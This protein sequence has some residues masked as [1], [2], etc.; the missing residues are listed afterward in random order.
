MCIAKTFTLLTHYAAH[1]AVYTS[2]ALRRKTRIAALFSH[3]VLLAAQLQPVLPVQESAVFTSLLVTERVD[4]NVPCRPQPHYPHHLDYR[5][6]AVPQSELFLLI[7]PRLHHRCMRQ[8]KCTL[9]CAVCECFLL[10]IVEADN[11]D[12]CRAVIM[13]AHRG[14]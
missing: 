3:G 13:P 7:P 14:F 11:T 1:K 10:K 8:F 2:G 4:G 9:V 6:S 5:T 12:A